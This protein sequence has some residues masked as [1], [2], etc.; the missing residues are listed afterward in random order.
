MNIP[1]EIERMGNGAISVFVR[2]REKASLRVFDADL[3]IWLDDFEEIPPYLRNL[4]PEDLKNPG[5]WTCFS[6]SAWL[7]TF[8]RNDP[9]LRLNFTLARGNALGEALIKPFIG[10]HSAVLL[11][12]GKTYENIRESLEKRLAFLNAMAHKGS[13]A[14]VFHQPDKIK[15]PELLHIA[16]RRV[17]CFFMDGQNGKTIFRVKDILGKSLLKKAGVGTH[18]PE[19][20]LNVRNT[21]R[22]IRFT[23]MTEKK[24]YS[25]CAENHVGMAEAMVLMNWL[26][27]LKD[28]IILNGESSEEGESRKKTH[29]I[30]N[31]SAGKIVTD[32]LFEAAQRNG[33]ISYE[34][35]KKNPLSPFLLRYFGLGFYLNRQVLIP[36]LVQSSSEKKGKI[37]GFRVKF[38]LP[39]MHASQLPGLSVKLM[40]AVAENKGGKPLMD[41]SHIRLSYNGETGEIW[42]KS[43]NLIV[44]TG[45]G[46]KGRLLMRID[47]ALKEMYPGIPIDLKYI[48]KSGANGNRAK[49]TNPNAASA[50]VFGAFENQ[51]SENGAPPVTAGRSKAKDLTGKKQE[52]KYLSPEEYDKK[53]KAFL[54][55]DPKLKFMRNTVAFLIAAFFITLLLIWIFGR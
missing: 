32:A 8:R 43:K 12:F 21:L 17:P 9:R 1:H 46:V 51:S 27:E 40:D 53:L 44:T 39:N 28:F 30:G 38:T 15:E 10:T 4:F 25:L 24:F 36:A 19:N 48:G 49:D 2:T 33:L 22:N 42:E 29:L 55:D 16:D 47:T 41:K 13:V 23:A 6:N 37:S 35:I 20:W 50:E 5:K 31:D 52:Q 14:A 34:Y 45:M 11:H 54:E 26:A 18:W 7:F 3:L